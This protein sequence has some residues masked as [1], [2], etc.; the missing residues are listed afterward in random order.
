MRLFPDDGLLLITP[1]VEWQSCNIFMRDEWLSS[2][3]REA[4]QCSYMSSNYLSRADMNC[5]YAGMEGI[6]RRWMII[7]GDKG[8][9]E[10]QLWIHQEL[11]S[12]YGN[13]GCLL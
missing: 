4:C 12:E 11:N 2:R 10:Q 1:K 6:E 3:Y 5:S 8:T 13:L 9:L 7:E